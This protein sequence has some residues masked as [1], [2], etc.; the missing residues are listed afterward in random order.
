MLESLEEQFM[1][2]RL[3]FGDEK[4]VKPKL[5]YAQ[6]RD[7]RWSQVLFKVEGKN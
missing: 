7:F 6:E 1:K 3:R 2:D 5:V 4:F